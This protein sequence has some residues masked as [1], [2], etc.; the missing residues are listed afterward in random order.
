MGNSSP[1]PT[2]DTLLDSCAFEHV[3]SYLDTQ[4]FNNIMKLNRNL[5]TSR[6]FYSKKAFCI[7]RDAKDDSVQ[8]IQT[9][10]HQVKKI[11]IGMNI[12][13]LKILKGSPML[14]HLIVIDNLDHPIDEASAALFMD[15]LTSFTQ[16]TT[17]AIRNSLVVNIAH[18]SSLTKVTKL[19][20]SENR[21]L[22]D[23]SHLAGMT[24]LTSLN[25]RTT[26][27]VVISHLSGL[28]NLKE[29]DLSYTDILEIR[30]L[31]GMKRLTSLFLASVREH[32]DGDFS[33]LSEL[34]QL[35]TL[36]LSRNDFDEIPTFLPQ[37]KNLIDLDLSHNELTDIS[38]VAGLTQLT[39]LDLSENTELEVTDSLSSLVNLLVLGLSYTAADFSPLSKLTKLTELSLRGIE[40]LDDE[41]AADLEPLFGLPNLVGLDLRECPII[42]LPNELLKMTQLVIR[43]DE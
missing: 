30:S 4:E 5:R 9:P 37:L 21:A 33:P 41:A 26:G 38:R 17:L 19:D 10:I 40:E 16:L 7:P 15:L 1:P 27:V 6:L 24:Q 35:T 14:R 22:V 43:Q 42:D 32:A 39:R 11:E 20:L 25:L 8:K 31:S 12:N 2:V 13:H 36:D 18:L 23:I 34:T 3:A 29:L 28:I